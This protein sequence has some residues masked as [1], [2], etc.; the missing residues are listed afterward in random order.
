MYQLYNSDCLVGLEA[1]EDNT[2]DLALVDPPY[3]DYVTHHRQDKDS[4]LSKGIV[5][6]SQEDQL[7]VIQECIRVLKPGSAFFVFTNWENIWWMQQ[8]FRTFFRN[9]IV[10]DK[11]NWTAGSLKDSLA[12]KYEI[13]FLGVKDKGWEI[14]GNRIPDIW[15]IPRASQ[16]K[17]T[18]PTEKPVDL[19]KKCIEIATD[20][21]MWV[22]DPYAGSGS[23]IVAALALDRNILAWEIDKYYYD[24]IQKKMGNL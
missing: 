24:L 10:W 11:G 7:R 15:E 1:L 22:I 18:H 16:A 6:Q 5:Q 14:R 13:A 12:N 4:K 20:P 19:Y 9:M 21:G 3:T 2:F 23:S 17:R 8:R